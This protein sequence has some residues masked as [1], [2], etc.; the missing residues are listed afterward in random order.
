MRGHRG[1][2]SGLS[3][4]GAIGFGAL[5]A[6]RPF[7]IGALALVLVAST[8]RHWTLVLVVALEMLQLPITY[9]G[10]D[11]SVVQV[12]QGLLLYGS[13]LALILTGRLQGRMPVYA[14]A[15][16]VPILGP[17]TIIG[18]ATLPPIQV[19]IGLN[20]ILM[21]VAA[22]LISSVMDLGARVR[23]LQIFILLM[24][25]NLAACFVELLIGV[26][27]LLALGLEYGTE[28]REIDGVLRAPG[29]ME[30]AI[31]L[32]LASSALA[33]WGLGERFH[34]GLEE[35]KASKTGTIAI[36]TSVIVT[37]FATS[38]SA[39]VMLVVAGLTLA[40]QVTG[41]KG[42]GTLLPVSM[43]ISIVVGFWFYGAGARDSLMER[44]VVWENLLSQGQ[45]PFGQGIGS[46]GAATYSSLADT[47]ELFVD[48]YLLSLYIQTGFWGFGIVLI[49]LVAAVSWTYGRSPRPASRVRRYAR[50]VLLGVAASALFV[51]VWEYTG[52]MML[53]AI[54]LGAVLGHA[55]KSHE[56][57]GEMRAPQPNY[58]STHR[59]SQ[60][61]G[62]R[63]H[64]S[65]DRPRP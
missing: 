58:T 25:L 59:H 19:L 51:E 4:L 32:G 24:T 60:A 12:A 64:R 55:P 54:S 28:V 20:L 5:S 8:A 15:W 2:W 52:A 30:G 35:K 23:A 50:A 13:L 22:F 57:A 26:E 10:I 38:R 40:V 45:S 53:L 33:I 11:S 39:A 6:H 61:P 9:W 18:L 56:F 63:E 44:F 41:K 65:R 37:I 43:A 16:L 42:K 34:D 49:G 14:A 21:P 7:W 17:A 47:T 62:F 48:N 46:A 27:G 1:L 29:F 36:L 31:A 3:V